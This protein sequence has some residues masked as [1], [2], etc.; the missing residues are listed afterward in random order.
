MTSTCRDLV[1][2]SYS[3]K[4][5]RWLD[6]L[7]TQL[8]LYVRDGSIT[9]W[10]D[11]KI[12]PG[13]EW[14]DEIRRALARTKVAVL[15]VT[16]NFLASDFIHKNEL[17][18][19]LTEAEAGGVKILSIHVRASSYKMSPIQKYQALNNPEKPLAKMGLAERD[20]AWVQ[21]CDTIRQTVNPTGSLL[22]DTEQMVAGQ[23]RPALN[24]V[25]MDADPLPHSRLLRDLEKSIADG[26]LRNS[27]VAPIVLAVL[28]QEKEL[29]LEAN[30]NPSWIIVG[31]Q[32]S[33]EFFVPVRKSAGERDWQRDFAQTT[34]PILVGMAHSLERSADSQALIIKLCNAMAER[35]RLS[36][37]W[38]E[39]ADLFNDL[40]NAI[41]KNCLK[42]TELESDD[43]LMQLK[44]LTIIG[45]K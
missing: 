30:Y 5:K 18:P 25:H 37:I 15:L 29:E 4:D 38:P 8:T 42:A 43:V 17:T 44:G 3:R 2:V 34:T 11:E 27:K 12:Q 16:Q 39:E 36:L 45:P 9:V 23:I 14:P 32:L 22:D 26:K 6:D 35:L 1:F 24:V 20:A 13:S 28:R 41:Y 7:Q 33:D 40:V 21:I 19:L 10:S 31:I